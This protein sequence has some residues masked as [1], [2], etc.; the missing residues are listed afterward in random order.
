[1]II[2]E[3]GKDWGSMFRKIVIMLQFFTIIVLL[4]IS[5]AKATPAGERQYLIMETTGYCPCEICCGDWADGKTFTGDKAG[6]GCIAIDPKNGPL[7]LGDKVYIEGYGY[8]TCNDIGGA[9]K[10][11]DA[12]CCYN[13]HEE[14][15][16]HGIQLLKVYKVK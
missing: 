5:G 9:I 11:W 13:T 3:S 8:A 7:R 2:C 14:A 6:K 10:N 12:D 4:I 1:M 16:N 15:L